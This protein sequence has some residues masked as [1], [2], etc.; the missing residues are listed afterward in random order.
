[1]VCYIA[2]LAHQLRLEK[3]K[4]GRLEEENGLLKLKIG[5][6]EQQLHE[7]SNS[8]ARSGTPSSTCASA[9]AKVS[10]KPSQKSYLRP[11]VSSSNRSKTAEPV[12]EE[13][14]APPKVDVRYFKSE[15]GFTY[16]YDD[17]R[18]V[19]VTHLTGVVSRDFCL[20][21]LGH[22]NPTR[23]M[24]DTESSYRKIW[25]SWE[26][27]FSD[28]G[29]AFDSSASYYYSNTSTWVD[30][31]QDETQPADDDPDETAAP[32]PESKKEI[33]EQE[34][35][36][37]DSSWE[38]EAASYVG[39]PSTIGY[40]LL[41]EAL[42]LAKMAFHDFCKENLPLLWK[43]KF[44]DGYTEVRFEWDTNESYLRYWNIP[45]TPEVRAIYVLN[46]LHSARQLRNL[47]SHFSGEIM[48]GFDYDTYI[49]RAQ[50]MAIAVNDVARAAE[51]R[52]LRDKLRKVAMDALTAM[53]NMGYASL[54]Q[55][56]REWEP[57]HE[58]FLRSISQYEEDFMINGKFKPSP[59]LRLAAQSCIWQSENYNS[60]DSDSEPD[61]N[62]DETKL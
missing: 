22:R 45:N 56:R 52:A 48:R 18:L 31:C 26:H 29:N 17:G 40:Q 15:K 33:L 53:E 27:G 10:P 47:V 51:V 32:E 23:Y 39:I 41:D 54:V 25:K 30:S 44:Q 2:P 28:W 50:Q 38:N 62:N 4:N 24:Q 14:T 46:A 61:L 13:K 60:M 8:G 43:R 5:A 20:T 21:Q 6:L 7:L 57:C 58:R 36:Y 12:E 34:T 9:V 35:R 19:D 16:V 42:D 55:I 1:M 11:T 3:E 49:K 59:A 37:D